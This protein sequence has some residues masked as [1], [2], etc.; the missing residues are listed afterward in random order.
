VHQT[1]VLILQ[2]P[3][4]VDHAKNTARLLHLCLPNSSMTTGEAFDLA[5]L[6]AAMPTPKYTVLLY[7]Q[8]PHDPAPLADPELLRDPTQVRLI[9]LDATW[10]KSRKMLHQSPGLRHLPRLPLDAVPA[11]QYAIR[12][13][14][15]LGQLSTLEATCAAL[16]QLEG[17]APKFQPLLQAFQG[18]V[19][20]QQAFVPR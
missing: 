16:A 6:S 18:F 5:N 17:D 9:V 15:K 12:K 20:Q 2:H 8:I 3:L 1:E 7:P 13:A 14:H 19:A 10:R 4:E 11:S